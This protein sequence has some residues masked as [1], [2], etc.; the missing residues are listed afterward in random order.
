MKNNI[1][2]RLVG[3]GTF[4]MNPRMRLYL[5]QVLDSGRISYGEKSLAFEKRFAQLHDCEYA[6]LSNSG[7]SA[8]EVALQAMKELN[9]W[10][11]GDEVIVPATTFVATA[12]IVVHNGMNPVFVDVEPI[13]YG[14]NPMHIEKVITDK[15]RA[16]I[17]VHLFGQPCEMQKIM[18]IA[19]DHDLLVIEDSCESMFATHHGEYVGSMGDIGCFSTYVA[20]LIV[21][22]VG[23]I[24]TTNNRAY[25]AKIRSL[26]NHGIELEFL[27]PGDNFAP[28]PT[29][30]RRFKFDTFGHSYRITEMEAALGL[31]QVDDLFIDDMLKRRHLN[32]DQLSSGLFKLN[33][34]H[35]DIF[36][37]PKT[38][39]YNT[40]SWMMYPILLDRGTDKEPFMQYLNE[41]MIETRDML[42]ILN[43]TCYSYLNP[44]DFPISQWIVDSGFYVGCHQDLDSEDIQYVLQTIESYLEQ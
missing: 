38:L 33:K 5:N 22:G 15:T 17:P 42:P 32:A 25:A 2:P 1:T 13:T 30:G 9:G 40:H 29:V 26:V 39:K 10:N 28:N 43:Q 8:L 41:H 14:I 3:V 27:N 31:A 21:T 7:T 44:I 35:N 23:G 19:A 24:C 16:I 18:S 37:I 36:N 20:H 6:I 34:Q 4:K 12:N 11:D